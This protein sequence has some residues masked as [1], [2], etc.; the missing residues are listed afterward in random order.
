MGRQCIARRVRRRGGRCAPIGVHRAQI[1][2]IG[3]MRAV[4][5]CSA[6]HRH[7]VPHHRAQERILRG[8]VCTLML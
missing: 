8:K 1:N 4:R 2:L 5:V 7:P 6:T 3:K